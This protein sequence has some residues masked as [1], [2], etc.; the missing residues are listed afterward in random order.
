MKLIVA[1]G[2]QIDML[3]RRVIAAVI[4]KVSHPRATVPLALEGSLPVPSLH[5]GTIP[6][7]RP[8][9]D[10]NPHHCWLE[11]ATSSLQLQTSDFQHIGPKN[12]VFTFHMDR[13]DF[14]QLYLLCFH[15][16]ILALQ[17]I[18]FAFTTFTKHRTTLSKHKT[19]SPLLSHRCP[20]TERNPFVFTTFLKTGGGGGGGGYYVN[21]PIPSFLQALCTTPIGRSIP[22]YRSW[23]P[24][25]LRP[26]GLYRDES[27]RGY[28]PGIDPA[29]LCKGSSC[30]WYQKVSNHSS[31]SFQSLCGFYPGGRG[32]GVRHREVKVPLAPGH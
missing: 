1:A 10:M 18:T 28:H 8:I 17:V 7:S 16:V 30:G 29:N 11:H 32:W 5:P 31:A 24:R 21:L 4:L 13:C 25:L 9:E 3:S 14:T 19:S 15:I 6:A 27:Y 2:T 26:D 23:Q 22:T 12:A 20:S